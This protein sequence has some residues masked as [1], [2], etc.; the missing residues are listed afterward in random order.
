[1]PIRLRE[2]IKSSLKRFDHKTASERHVL[3]GLLRIS[4]DE[5]IAHRLRYLD[6]VAEQLKKIRPTEV[7]DSAE[8]TEKAE[9]W[10]NKIKLEENPAKVF[11]ELAIECGIDLVDDPIEKSSN[12][13]SGLAVQEKTEGSKLSGS[14]LVSELSDISLEDAMNELNAMIGLESV[15]KQINFLISTH[16]VNNVRIEKGLPAIPQSLHLVFSG[17]P[18]TGK[19]SVARLVSQ[20]YKSLEI[21]PVGHLVEVSRADLVAGFVGQTAIKVQEVVENA[22]GG[23]LFID[24][25]YSLAFDA[26]AGFGS[27]AISTLLQHMENNR[28]KFAVIAAGYTDQ[29]KDFVVSNPGLRSRFQTFIDFPNYTSEQLFE[30]FKKFS[31]D[32]HIKLTPEVEQK[33]KL[34]FQKGN[35]GG[36]SG[37]ARYVR[38]LFETMFANLAHRAHE[39]GHIADHELEAFEVEDIPSE[40]LKGMSTGNRIGFN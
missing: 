12:N 7:D 1:M 27:E 18:G 6:E 13:T 26:G 36:D 25:A 19:T 37:N 14:S 9:Y 17:D 30:I 11:K 33:L 3:F 4:T 29:M 28:G 15:K 38:G 2:E 35:F 5:I 21:L 34:H 10:L 20:I 31:N 16:T 39:D 24:E 8:F 23:V 40:P 22:F 32:Y